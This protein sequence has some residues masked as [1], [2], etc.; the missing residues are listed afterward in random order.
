[1]SDQLNDIIKD[2]VVRAETTR[3]SHLFF[4]SIFLSHFVQYETAPFQ[5]EMFRI[6][7]DPSIKLGVVTAFRGSG[8]STI[9]TLSLPIWAVLGAPQKKFVLILTKT[10]AQAKIH[11]ANLKH[12]LEN[13]ELLRGDLGPFQ[14]DSAE[15]GQYSIV[16]TKYNARITAASSEQSIRGLRHGEHRPDLIIV[17]DPEDLQSVK[18]LEGRDKTYQ[19]LTGEVMPGGDK[20][21]K[22]IVV[23]NLLHEDSV[24]MRLK[25]GIE[26]GILNGIYREFPLVDAEDKIAWPGKFPDMTAIEEL[27][28][29]IGSESAFQREFLLHI[30]TSDDQIIRPEWI[31]YYDDLPS[32]DADGFRYV[33][34]GVDLAISE[35]VTADFTAMV[36]ARIYHYRDK[37]KIYILPNPVN[38]RMDFPTT[39]TCAM[40]LSK[41][42]G[43][44]VPTKLVIE[45]VGYQKS[46][47]DHLRNLNFPAEGL[48]PHG[49]DKRERASS[50]SHL[51]QQGK[52]L[53]PRH[54]T[55]PLIT[56]MT[57]FGRE[58]HDDLLDAL[59]TMLL[60]VMGND[61]SGITIPDGPWNNIGDKKPKTREELDYEADMDLIRESNYERSGYDPSLRNR[62]GGCGNFIW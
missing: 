30:V 27:K 42:L 49:Q 25:D 3:R 9:M 59:V 51:I 31:Q 19:W 2:P 24:M 36:S 37:L 61:T 11:F 28:R 26:K 15:W 32:E 54:G 35:K 34:T 43:G 10:Q 8:K 56:Q 29:T 40:S 16:L 39:V 55:E 4:H 62:S 23:G 7:E 12:E 53:F 45:E 38:V 41:T 17:D 48:G 5:K 20:N 57:G 47:I 33:V 22:I 18:T 14:D 6:T 1:M 52:V 50:V 46:I 58:R 60:Y 21:T 44:G 13:N